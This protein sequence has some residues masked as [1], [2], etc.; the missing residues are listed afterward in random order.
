MAAIT[1]MYLVIQKAN[2]Q[3]ILMRKQVKVYVCT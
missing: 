1:D 3:N 2:N